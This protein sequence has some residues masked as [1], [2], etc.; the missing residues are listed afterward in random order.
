[1]SISENSPKKPEFITLDEPLDYLGWASRNWALIK[2]RKPDIYELKIALIDTKPAV[3]RTILIPGD[4]TLNKL[5]LVIQNSF[6]W[7]NYHLFQFIGHGKSKTIETVFK[8]KK[9]LMYEYDFGTTQY[10]LI[11]KVKS[12]KFSENNA[13]KVLPVCIEGSRFAPF[14]DSSDW[15]YMLEIAQDKKHEEYKETIDWLKDMW[16]QTTQGRQGKFILSRLLDDSI[17]LLNINVK[18]SRLQLYPTKEYKEFDIPTTIKS[19]K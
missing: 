16:E 19:I 5:H 12:Y 1:M 15:D 2:A 17:N 18:L 11:K 6:N 10:H 13:H 8:N 9:E 4:V 14:E 3:Y 7:W